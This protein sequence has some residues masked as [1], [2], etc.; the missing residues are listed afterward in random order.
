MYRTIERY[1]MNQRMIKLLENY[2]STTIIQDKGIV[3]MLS[4]VYR[5]GLL[6]RKPITSVNN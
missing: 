2:S 6:T 5:D 1:E 3:S 4:A